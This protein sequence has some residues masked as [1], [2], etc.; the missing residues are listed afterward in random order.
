M[1]CEDFLK[2]FR[3]ALSSYVCI[4]KLNHLLKN[5]DKSWEKFVSV[6]MSRLKSGMKKEQMAHSL[7]VTEET[8][9]CSKSMWI[10]NY[11]TPER[12]TR[13]SAHQMWLLEILFLDF[14]DET[15]LKFAME[16]SSGVPFS[17]EIILLSSTLTAINLED[18][19]LYIQRGIDISVCVEMLHK[20]W[21][22]VSPI[23]IVLHNTDCQLRC[24]VTNTKCQP[25]L[26]VI[27]CKNLNNK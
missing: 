1:L 26:F 15:L 16:C 27:P 25:T 23:L 19:K 7:A 4:L 10:S 14:H 12:C 21:Y 20:M 8:I 9:S 24:S 13:C 22:L 18:I 2:K 5:L 3:Y 17:V 6:M 11:F